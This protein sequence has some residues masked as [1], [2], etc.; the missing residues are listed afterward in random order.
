MTQRDYLILYM[1]IV[2]IY[3]YHYRFN[4]TFIHLFSYLTHSALRVSSETRLCFN[5]LSSMDS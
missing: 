1:N 2:Y 3:L 5:K 4:N